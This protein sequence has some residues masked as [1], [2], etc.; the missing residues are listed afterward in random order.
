MSAA[1]ING[2]GPSSYSRQSRQGTQVY[3]AMEVLNGP[4]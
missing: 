4:V 1:F 3:S 2:Q